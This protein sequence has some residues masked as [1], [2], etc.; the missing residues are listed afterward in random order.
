MMDKKDLF[1]FFLH[2]KKNKTVEEIYELFV[3][4]NYDITKLDIAR[5]YRYLD[6]YNSC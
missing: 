3:K 5:F 6:K 2:L 1:S 4:E